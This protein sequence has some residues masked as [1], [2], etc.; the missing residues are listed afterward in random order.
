MVSHIGRNLLRTG[1]D[2]KYLP[3]AVFTLASDAKRAISTGSELGYLVLVC[4]GDSLWD[5]V[6][7]FDSP[8]NKQWRALDAGDTFSLRRLYYHPD[9]L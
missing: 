6:F 1:H 2:S 5:R 7:F 4:F 3:I 9:L 8:K